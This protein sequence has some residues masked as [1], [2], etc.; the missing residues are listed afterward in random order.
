MKCTIL[1]AGGFKP[2]HKGHYDF[3]KFYLDDPTVKKVILFC[4]D[5]KRDGITLE[6]TEALLAIYGLLDHPKL[7]YRR[8]TIRNGRKG[9]YTN[10]L[11]DCYDWADDNSD[12]VCGLGW[13]EKD[14]LYQNSF[15]S[16]FYGDSTIVQP[17]M[18]EMKDKLSATDFRKALRN[19]D[20]IAHFLPEGVCEQEVRSVLGA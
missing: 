2:P 9:A 7:D 5:K 1:M 12:I 8:A 4:G 15:Q 14:A 17:P 6:N 11:N 18:F 13:S 3:I 16:Y 20:T 10:P 19:G